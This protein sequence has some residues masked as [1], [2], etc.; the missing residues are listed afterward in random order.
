MQTKP[1]LN[2]IGI[3]ASNVPRT[4][5]LVI[6][7]IKQ[8]FRLDIVLVNLPEPR[9]VITAS[10]TRPQISKSL[11]GT[12]TR[13]VAAGRGDASG[14]SVGGWSVRGWGRVRWGSA[15]AGGCCCGR[16]EVVVV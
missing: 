13:L 8:Q 3:I 15:H 16:W 11:P 14:D 1:H 5:T 7:L 10:T 9:C 4:R 2:E 12:K 6:R